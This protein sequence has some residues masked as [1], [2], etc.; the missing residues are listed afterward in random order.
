MRDHRHTGEK[1]TM[2]TPLASPGDCIVGR[3]TY[4]RDGAAIARRDARQ[5]GA[6]TATGPSAN[7]G[8]WTGRI[9]RNPAPTRTRA[10]KRQASPA[11]LKR[12]RAAR[13]AEQRQHG[14]LADRLAA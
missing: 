12:L 7:N 5:N 3:A 8:D 13:N 2:R 11:E 10:V 6:V 9:M 14:R 1:V 4:S